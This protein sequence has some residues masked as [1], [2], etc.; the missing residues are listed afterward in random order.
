[1]KIPSARGAIGEIAG[2]VG[3]VLMPVGFL[4]DIADV[5]STGTR[6]FK[7]EVFGEAI[8]IWAFDLP[9]PSPPCLLDCK[10]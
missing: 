5:Q 4:K 10:M 2:A 9:K 7:K 8:S 1:M 6:N 3:I